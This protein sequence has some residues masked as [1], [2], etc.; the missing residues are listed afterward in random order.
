MCISRPFYYSIEFNHLLLRFHDPVGQS[1]LASTV[2]HV[3]QAVEYDGQL[4]QTNELD[5]S[6]TFRLI[7]KVQHIFVERH[8]TIVLQVE[9]VHHIPSEALV[10][11]PLAKVPVHCR[12][13]AHLDEQSP[14]S[15][16]GPLLSHPGGLGPLVGWLDGDVAE[17]QTSGVSARPDMATIK[18]TIRIR[19]EVP[20]L[21]QPEE[22]R[23]REQQQQQRTTN[24]LVAW[25]SH[26]RD[27]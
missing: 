14:K 3:G 6:F 13:G 27:R 25:E 20:I 4:T 10:L 19:P 2:R 7:L 24:H 21:Q 17:N 18:P 26:I 15:V 8:E 22:A 5:P 12:S 16:E 9:F 11:I 23:G 1:S